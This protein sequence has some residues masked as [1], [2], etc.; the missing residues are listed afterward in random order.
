MQHQ[1]HTKLSRPNHGTFARN[2]WAIIGTPCGNIKSL[3]FELTEKL[4]AKYK[5]AYVDADHKGAEEENIIG[6]DKK[7]ALAFGGKMEYTDKISFHRVDFEGS[8]D[9]FSYRQW[10]N[11]Q[12]LVLV[13][14]NHFAAKNQIV[15]IDPEKEASLQKKLDRL[16]NVSLLLLP[17]GQ[18]DIFPF[19]REHLKDQQVPVL[20]ISDTEAIS[21]FIHEQME[22]A[23][24][25]VYGLVLAGGKSVRMGQDKGLIN[26]HGKPQREFAA[27]LLKPYCEQVFISCR[28]DQLNEIES[29]YE[30]LPDTFTGLGPYGAIL[31]AF[32]AFPDHAWFVIACDLPLLDQETV[33]FLLKNRNASKTASAF[34]SPINQ[35]PE[36]L[37]AIWEPK[38]Y[39]VLLQFLAQGYSCP[40]KVLINSEVKLLTVPDEKTLINVNEKADLGNI[41]PHLSGT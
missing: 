27:D 10:F 1:K 16:E 40:R 24:P 14:G 22:L 38:A 17:E 41:A 15:V 39:P 35:F 30:L 21:D 37:I 4:S 19:L 13:N 3:A 31:S 9:H 32:R 6:R 33:T 28:Q 20:S 25:K 26:Y 8:M 2:E 23:I 18:K 5:V 12:D 11:D 29:T 7:S 34:I 36:P